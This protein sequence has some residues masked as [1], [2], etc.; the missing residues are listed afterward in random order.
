MVPGVITAR[1]MGP[2]RNMARAAATSMAMVRPIAMPVRRR[3]RRAILSTN[4]NK[5]SLTNPTHGGSIQL[6]A[7]CALYRTS[8]EQR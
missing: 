4:N 6:S 5:L 3:T 2:A 7:E 1:P 8:D